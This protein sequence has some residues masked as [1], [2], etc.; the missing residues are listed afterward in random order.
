MDEDEDEDEEGQL[1]SL[2]LIM[3]SRDYG[4]ETDAQSR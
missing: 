4:N 1:L 2:Q 3:E